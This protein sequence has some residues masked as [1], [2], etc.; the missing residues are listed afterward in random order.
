MPINASDQRN[1]LAKACTMLF[2]RSWFVLGSLWSYA[3]PDSAL[4]E[5]PDRIQTFLPYVRETSYTDMTPTRGGK[6]TKDN[7][8][9]TPE[10]RRKFPGSTA[11]RF[12][13][14]FYW[15]SAHAASSPCALTMAF[16]RLRAPSKYWRKKPHVA[17]SAAARLPA[18]RKGTR[19]LAV[20]ASTL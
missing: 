14:A 1:T 5:I 13:L 9:V 2:S 17:Y 6:W 7:T 15:C 16:H 4:T 19:Y 18:K 3:P 20:K 11:A 8:R 10:R 12:P